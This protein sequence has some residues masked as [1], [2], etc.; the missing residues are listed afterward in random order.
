MKIKGEAAIVTGAAS[1]IGADV[2]RH[3]AEAGAKVAVL[4]VNKAGA[5]AVAKEIGG[6]GFECDVSSAASA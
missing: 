5:E 3:L 4:D 6:R 1:G 2:A